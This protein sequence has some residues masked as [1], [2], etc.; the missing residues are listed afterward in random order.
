MPRLLA[1]HPC[2]AIGRIVMSMVGWT[3][4]TTSSKP[5]Y[6]ANLT[7]WMAPCRPWRRPQPAGRLN[8]RGRID[9]DSPLSI[10]GKVNP[11]APKLYLQLQPGHR[12]RADP[13]LTPYSAKCAGYPITKGKLSVTRSTLI[14]SNEARCAEPGV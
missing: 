2:I 8:L 3:L 5:N 6:A 12:H 7:G 10:S 1:L 4:P 13:R 14:D 11:L 9:H